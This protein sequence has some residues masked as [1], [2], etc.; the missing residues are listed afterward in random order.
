MILFSLQRQV[1]KIKGGLFHTCILEDYLHNM[2]S[3]FLSLEKSYENANSNPERGKFKRDEAASKVLTEQVRK[4]PFRAAEGQWSLPCLPF[5]SV[6]PLPTLPLMP[7]TFICGQLSS[8]VSFWTPPEPRELR[9]VN[10][11][12]RCFVQWNSIN[13]RKLYCYFGSRE[14]IGRGKIC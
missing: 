12:L 13:R 2:W 9:C 11:E 4:L 8:Q 14:E 3:S 10:P 5:Q 1:N 6:L 7:S